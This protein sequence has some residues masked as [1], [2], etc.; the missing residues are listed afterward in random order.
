MIRAL[1]CLS[2]CFG[3]GLHTVAGF[4]LPTTPRTRAWVLFRPQCPGDC[5]TPSNKACRRGAAPLRAYPGPPDLPERPDPSILIA[6]RSGPEQQDAVFALAAA[7]V[8]GTGI[9]AA[10]LG[11]VESALPRG[12]F[13][14][15]R[16]VT[17]SPALG[18]IFATA[19][20]THFTVRDAFCRIVPPYGCWGGLWRIPAPGAAALGLDYEEFHVYWTGV[21]EIL[22]G[23]WLAG[24]GLGLIDGDP[25]VPS[26]LL[27]MLV[28]TN[29]LS[30][31]SIFIWFVLKKQ[32]LF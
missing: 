30:V 32:S 15:W 14:T 12:W 11:G 4:A 5:P 22:G 29:S 27:G 16:D 23:V 19:G 3:V 10:L 21:A 24:S 7:L 18:L 25:K 31:C 28:R 2:F 9:C 6:A 1:A 26:A 17:W 20:V 8:L 13:A